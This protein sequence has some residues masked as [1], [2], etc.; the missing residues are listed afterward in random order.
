MGSPGI[1]LRGRRRG[2]GLVALAFGCAC[3]ALAGP[4][5]AELVISE[6]LY[7][8]TGDEAGEWIEIYNAGTEAVSLGDYAVGDEQDPGSTTEMMLALPAVSLPPRE[9]AVIA[10]DAALVTPAQGALLLA[11]ANADPDKTITSAFPGW[12]GT[13][14]GGLANSG[15]E[16]ILIKSDG[17]GG[18]I[19]VDGVAWGGGDTAV[20]GVPFIDV[21]APIGAEGRSLARVD[22]LVDG[23]LAADWVVQVSPTPGEAGPDPCGNGL[24]NTGEQCDDGGAA[25]GDGCDDACQV[26]CGFSCD[27]AGAGSCTP[28][29]GD[30]DRVGDE[31]C[32]DGSDLPGDGCAP[33]CTVEDGWV[34][35]DPDP[36]CDGDPATTVSSCVPDPCRL[37]LLLTE[38]HVDAAEDPAGEWIELFN[39]GSEAIELTSWAVGDEETQGATGEGLLAFPAGS[40]VPPGG[41]LVVAADAARFAAD[42]GVT[43]DFEYG[44]TDP[45]VPDLAPEGSWTPGAAVDLANDGDEVVLVCRDAIRDMVAWGPGAGD[46]ILAAPAPYDGTDPS[47]RSTFARR[48]PALDTDLAS[49]WVVSHCPSPKTT[50]FADA[51]PDAGRAVA[52]VPVGQSVDLWLPGDDPTGD[53]LFFEVDDS[54]ALGTVTVLDAATGAARYTAPGG[55]FSGADRFHFTVSDGCTTSAPLPFDVEVGTVGCDPAAP[56]LLLGEIHVDARVDNAGEWIELRNPTDQPVSLSWLRLG[57]E[58]SRGGDEGMFAFPEDAW[59]GAQDVVVVAS[60]AREFALD[61]GFLPD[62][63]WNA[64]SDGEVGDDLP[65]YGP[66]SGGTIRLEEASDEVYLLDCDGVV[67][68]SVYWGALPSGQSPAETPWSTRLPA[69]AP[70]YSGEAALG[71]YSF[72]RLPGIADS[73][74]AADWYQQRCPA[75]GAYAPDDL[76]PTAA[77]GRYPMA[78]EATLDGTLVGAGPEDQPLT[79]LLSAP[80][81]SGFTL[82]DATSGA[83][84]YE[85]PPGFV[86][87]ATVRYVVDDGCSASATASVVFC[88]GTT[89]I[90]GNAVD[91]DC[92]GVITCFVD[93]DGDGW[94]SYETAPDD[95]DGTCDSDGESRFTGDCDDD[96]GACGADCS[97]VGVELCDGRDNDCDSQS[98]DGDDDPEVG[99]ACDAPADANACPD[100][101]RAC[102]GGALVCVDSPAGD[103]SRVEVCDGERTDEDCDGGADDDDPDGPPTD[104]PTR[105]FDADGD[106]WG[107]PSTEAAACHPGA[108]WVDQG[109]DC[110]DDPAACGA[111]CHPGRL[112][113]LAAGNCDDGY[114]NDCDDV[115][116]DQDTACFEDVVCFP[117]ADGDGFGVTAEATVLTGPTAGAGCAAWDDGVHATGYWVAVGGDCDDSPSGCGAA[118]SPVEAE[119]CDGEDNDCSGT[120]PDGYDD[121]LA[122]GACDSDADGDLCEDD[123]P[124]CSGGTLSCA[125]DP[126]GDGQRVEVCD[127]ADLDEDCDGGADDLD[128]DGV[129]AGAVATWADA[130]GDGWGDPATEALRCDVGD[131]RVTRAG[132]CDDDPNAC[133]AACNPDRTESLGAANCAD[134]WNNDCDGDG[135]DVDNTCFGST[136]CWAD[137]DGDGAGDATTLI[138]LDGTDALAG[139]AAWLDGTHPAGYWVANNQDCADDPNGCGA[140]CAP[141]KPDLCDG[142]DNDCDAG[143]PDGSGDVRIGAACDS[144]ADSDHCLDD[145]RACVGGA[146]VCQNDATGDTSQIEVCDPADV[147]E[148]CDGGADDDDP[149]GV[150]AG[151]P[152][153]YADLDGDTYGDPLSPTV[154]CEKPIGYV[155]NGSDCD[156]DP[157]ACG[158]SCFPGSPDLCDGRDNDCDAGTPDGSGDP[159]VGLPCD[160]PGD[161]DSC[162]DEVTRCQLA[163]LTCPNDPV[164]DGLRVERCDAGGQDEDCDGGANDDDPDGPPE[165]ATTWFI[166]DDGDGYGSAVETIRACE[167]PAGYSASADDCDDDP[168]LCGAACAPDLTEAWSAD[169]CTDGW[170]NDCDDQ[171]DIGAGCT[172]EITCWPDFDGDGHG[173]P[174]TPNT[175]TGADAIAGCAAWDDDVHPVGFWVT[176]SDDCDDTAGAV[177]PGQTEIIGDG[178]DQDCSGGD[179]CWVDRDNDG[180]AADDAA[181][182][183]A[184][185]GKTCE[186]SFGLAAVAGDC[187]DDPLTCGAACG[188]D[189]L[190]ICD[191][192]DNDCDGETDEIASCGSTTPTDTPILFGGS[193]CAG[194]APGA[195]WLGLLALGW[196]RSRRSDRRTA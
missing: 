103:A 148:D 52:D 191:E 131:G 40:A 79:Y 18:W 62:F 130:D 42:F 125:N 50:A 2:R 137:A 194:G 189:A 30:G 24:L 193:G 190:E 81:P 144:A 184:P 26:E 102:V 63:E 121:L 142:E 8:P 35:T 195:W 166:D 70:P 19:L 176:T 58:E 129:P 54:A 151:A 93:A 51:P 105:W 122:I 196:L 138:V 32:D 157:A 45:E 128:P 181:T 55:G 134:G 90:P 75:P 27:G 113:S 14:W 145:R 43:P 29:C 31:G 25:P 143:T 141:G 101:T 111:A 69:P 126:E 173:D 158:A 114:D 48:D 118:C 164:D 39:A 153:W 155:A 21:T 1:Q 97:P 23:D 188:P 65:R 183:E 53:A 41:V 72:E 95:G 66:W 68:D 186:E 168:E 104:A 110:D 152:L 77:D 108:G 175:V 98:P 59:I 162:A 37:P 4:A 7:D 71:P 106:G 46:A 74:T 159:D 133:G 12:G 109:G 17:A 13:H 182:A 49:D 94:G 117:D 82:D 16:V 92:D 5:R 64:D 61:F 172:A 84:T 34:C 132:D 44:G 15:D 156:D 9:A 124:T 47:A 56:T 91:E 22:P 136:A 150:P 88:V 154:S 120:T 119:V 165:D 33:D 147:D 179:L 57:D 96:P 115:P 99:T 160:S 123:V 78:A 67:I 149:D 76:R 167:L 87:L 73:D 146:L 135:A 139:C 107:D 174:A 185:N 192:L 116:A 86:G 169:N 6:V 127:A 20:D 3:L 163:L 187:D 38:V 60:S 180:V 89:E 80:V 170:D 161:E 83:F 100:D 178:I 140:S 171:A 177:H 10:R 112:E 85:P 11:L 28:D 36:L